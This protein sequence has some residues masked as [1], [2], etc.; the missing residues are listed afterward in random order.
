MLTLIVITVG[1]V[2]KKL[3]RMQEHANKLGM[4]GKSPEQVVL[5]S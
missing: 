1:R 3:A 4:G 5:A 2:W